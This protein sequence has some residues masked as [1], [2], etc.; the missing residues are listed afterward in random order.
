MFNTNPYAWE[1]EAMKQNHTVAD[2]DYE[3]AALRKRLAEYERATPAGFIDRCEQFVA[4]N[5]LPFV[6]GFLFGFVVILW[7]IA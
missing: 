2:R 7:R 4:R 3:L 5:V 1:H 6:A